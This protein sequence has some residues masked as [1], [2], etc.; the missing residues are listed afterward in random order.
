MERA[1]FLQL[2]N[3]CCHFISFNISLGVFSGNFRGEGWSCV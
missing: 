1:D 3:F 2:S